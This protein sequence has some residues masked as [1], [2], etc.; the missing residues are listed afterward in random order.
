[1]SSPPPSRQGFSIFIDTVCEGRVPLWWDER[2]RPLVYATEREAQR[3]IADD[4]RDRLQQFLD[5]EREFEDAMMVEEY[6]LPVSV[7]PDGAVTTAGG[8]CFLPRA[9]GA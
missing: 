6:I 7:L 5:G 1:V 3:E 8:D 9:T 4:L 2:G